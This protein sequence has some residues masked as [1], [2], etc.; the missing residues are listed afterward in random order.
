MPSDAEWETL[1][2]FL[3]GEY[4]AGAK[5]KEIGNTHWSAENINATN[6]SGFTA[7]PGGKYYVDMYSGQ[8][9][10]FVGMGLQAFFWT[11][12]EHTVEWDHDFA[13]IYYLY[14]DEDEVNSYSHSKKHGL[15]VRCLKD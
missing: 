13:R 9:N 1:I 8:E 12:T 14:D 7:L 4:I 6:S 5:L 11:T 15:S 2:N 10:D 3:G